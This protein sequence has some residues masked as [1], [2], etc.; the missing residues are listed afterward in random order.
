MRLTVAQALVRFLANQWSERDGV[1]HR[2]IAGVFGIFGHGNVAGIGQALAERGAGLGD[3]LPYYLARN[4]QAMVHTAVGY[5]RALDRMSTFACTTSIGPGATNLVTGAALATINR[6]PVLL[7]PGD[8]FATRVANP[9]LQ[10]LEDPRSYDVTVNDALRP[11][12]RFFD[13]INRPEQLPSAL[14]AAMRVLTDPAETGAVTLALPQDVQAEAY[15]WPEELFARRVWHVAR[16]VPEPAALERALTLLKDS[17][18]PLIVAGGGVIYSGASSDLADFAERYGVPVAETQAGKGSLRHDHP[19]NAGAIGHTGTA[20]ANK[21]A[22]EADLVIGIGT[23][24]SD[25]TTASRTLFGRAR[26]LNVNVAAFDAAKHAGTM[27][28]ADARE[29]LRALRPDGWRASWTFEK[30]AYVVPSGFT[31]AAVLDA[32]NDAAGE[33]GVVVNAAGSMPGDLHRQW[34]AAGPHSYHVEY[35]YSCMGYEIAGGLGVKLAAPEREVF[36][37]VGDGSYLMMAQEIA[38]AVQEAVKLVIVLVDNGGFASIG[39]LSEA[40][41]ARR[42]G[43]SYRLRGPSGGLDGEPLPV[44]LAA[45]AASL[46]ADVL[47]AGDRDDLVAAL[48]KARESARTTVVYVRPEPGPGTEASAWWDVPVAEVADNPEARDA[49]THYE[50]AKRDQRLY[51]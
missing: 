46:G 36:V 18:R 49:R 32:V 6:I 22:R 20:A 8:V 31:Q 50:Q 51:L 39:G 47:R 23:R 35:G 44:D 4:E 17:R 25:F 28:V 16:P 11:V 9:V 2:L 15:D 37:L 3:A 14:L 19:W 21:L 43:T 42:L 26:F 45:N 40:V 1:E 30:P 5:A 12:S 34:R 27:L 7:L 33:D 38:T 13:R 10:E 29:A 41:G 24:Y 48:A